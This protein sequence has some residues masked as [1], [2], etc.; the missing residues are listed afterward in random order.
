MRLKVCTHQFV[1]LIWQQLDNIGESADIPAVQDIKLSDKSPKLVQRFHLLKLEIELVSVPSDIHAITVKNTVK[2][3]IPTF[4]MKEFFFMENTSEDMLLICK[5]IK[6]G[7]SI[8]QL[9]WT[10]LKCHHFF[11]LVLLLMPQSKDIKRLVVHVL[12][13]V[14]EVLVIWQFNMPT[15]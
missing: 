5:L 4:V 1:I 14:L 9:E 8:F 2:R 7:S 12:S 11:V 15:N 13:L 3:E 10:S 6:I